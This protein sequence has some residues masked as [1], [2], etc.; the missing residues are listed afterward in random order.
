MISMMLSSVANRTIVAASGNVY[1]ADQYG[2]IQN[3]S[4]PADVQSL[5]DAGCAVLS[6]PPTD[7]LGSLLNANFNSTSDQLITFPLAS[8]LKYRVKRIVV[9]DTTVNG[10]STAVGGFYSAASKGGSAIVAAS[11]AY[12]GLT[13]PLTALEPTIAL[14]NLILAAGTPLYFS[15]STPQGALATADIYVYGDVYE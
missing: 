10:M 5:I 6:P 11:Q 14:P 4:T 8:G 12:T 1:V 3:V 7:L 9:C 2:V 15:L 13:N